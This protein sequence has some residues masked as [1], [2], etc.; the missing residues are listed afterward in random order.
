MDVLQKWIGHPV[1]ARH[2]FGP[3]IYNKRFCI[4]QRSLMVFCRVAYRENTGMEFE[5]NS[6]QKSIC[7]LILYEVVES[8]FLLTFVIFFTT[9]KK[10]KE[11]K[12]KRKK[13]VIK[14]YSYT[15]K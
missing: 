5:W 15:V 6:F 8:K 10:E 2:C 12:R 7:I 9:R 3:S 1:P 4:C 13:R 11:K 14:V